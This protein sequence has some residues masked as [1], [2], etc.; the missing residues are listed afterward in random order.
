M[1]PCDCEFLSFLT[2]Y[3]PEEYCRNTEYSYNVNNTEKVQAS[4]K[5]EILVLVTSFIKISKSIIKLFK[6]TLKKSKKIN[7]DF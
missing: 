5:F 2:N 4:K 6:N 1:N 7:E 3:I